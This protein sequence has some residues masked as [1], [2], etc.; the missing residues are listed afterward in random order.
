MYGILYRRDNKEV[1]FACKDVTL[2]ANSIKGDTGMIAGW[3]DDLAF[4]C[5]E[6]E[7]PE[8]VEY[9]ATIG[10]RRGG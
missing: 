2:G 3:G 5:V 10:G 8:Y 1:L 9:K 6:E 4:I 7:P